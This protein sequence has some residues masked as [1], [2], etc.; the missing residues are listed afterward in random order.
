M[1]SSAAEQISIKFA[2]EMYC[3]PGKNIDYI[4]SRNSVP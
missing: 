2:E 4:L 1:D 3:I